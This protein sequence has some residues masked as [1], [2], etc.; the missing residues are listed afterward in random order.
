MPRPPKVKMTYVMEKDNVDR[1]RTLSRRLGVT[2]SDI[3]NCLVE[4]TEDIKSDVMNRIA[5]KFQE[6]ADKLR[7][8]ANEE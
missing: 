6:R 2:Q 5:D 1:V 7:R 8:M 3:V 4:L